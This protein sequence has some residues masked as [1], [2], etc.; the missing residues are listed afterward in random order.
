[1]LFIILKKKYIYI[2]SRIEI[3]YMKKCIFSETVFLENF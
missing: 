3:L 1:M 2:T